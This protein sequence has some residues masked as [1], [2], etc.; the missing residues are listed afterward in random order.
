MAGGV[1]TGGD[2]NINGGAVFTNG[3]SV[4]SMVSN[5]AG[6]YFGSAVAVKNGEESTGY[7]VGGRGG[8][9]AGASQAGR[10]GIIILEYLESY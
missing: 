8:Q 2:V 9:S 10:P 3:A 6:V 4:S 5:G 1:S 7:G